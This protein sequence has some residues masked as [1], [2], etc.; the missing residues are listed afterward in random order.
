MKKIEVVAA[1]IKK[2]GNIICCQREIN[3]IAKR[4]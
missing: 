1:I 3:K 4:I 2:N